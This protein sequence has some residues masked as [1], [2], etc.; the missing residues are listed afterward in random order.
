MYYFYILKCK[1]K[2]LYSGVTNN[3]EKREMAHNSGK[4]SKYVWAHG[5]GKIIYLEKFRA[6]SKALKREAEVKKFSRREKLDLIEMKFKS[7]NKSFDNEYPKLVRDRI[8]EIVFKKTVKK[9]KRRTLKN[10]S[11]YLKYLFKKVVEEAKELE[12]ALKQGNIQ[13]EIADI[14]EILDTIVKVKSLKWPE[15]KNLQ[16]EKRKKNGSFEKRIILLKK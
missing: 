3:L 10:N 2:S 15:I 8:P 7:T 1:D 9:V 11:E 16:K 12:F 6:L 13:E 14:M 5:G 4:G